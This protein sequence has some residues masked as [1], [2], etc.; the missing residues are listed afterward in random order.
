MLAACIATNEFLWFFWFYTFWGY[1]TSMFAILASVKAAAY[2]DSDFWRV[3][4]TYTNQW[5][6]CMN[7]LITPLFWLVLAPYIFP[8]LK[9]HGLDLFMRLHMTTLHAVP[10]ISLTINH[11]LTDIKLI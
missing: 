9:W 4:A 8:N 11:A 3:S 7:L 1:L 10:F 6:Q 5:G 2:P